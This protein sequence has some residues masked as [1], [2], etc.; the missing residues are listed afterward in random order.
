MTLE[1]LTE[2]ADWIIDH[3]PL[4][5]HQQADL[6]LTVRLAEKRGSV[7]PTDVLYVETLGL[8]LKFGFY[9][10]RRLTVAEK[11]KADKERQGSLF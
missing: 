6:I 8:P 10:V 1:E 2:K 5:P 11:K 9:P 3:R 7:R 4:K